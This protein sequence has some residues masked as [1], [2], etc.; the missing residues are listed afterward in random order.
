MEDVSTTKGVV[1]GEQKEGEQINTRTKLD[2]FQRNGLIRI[3]IALCLPIHFEILN[4]Q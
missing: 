2:I 1:H 4:D 3:G